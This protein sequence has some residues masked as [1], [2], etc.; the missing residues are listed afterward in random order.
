MCDPN[1]LI[2]R[3]KEPSD[4]CGND[5]FGQLSNGPETP[6]CNTRAEADERASPEV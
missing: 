5:V 2:S 6:S 4:G 3:L 1:H